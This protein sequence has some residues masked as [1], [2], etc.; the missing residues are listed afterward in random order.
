MEETCQRCERIEAHPRRPWE[1]AMI[2]RS[3]KRD[4]RGAFIAKC[5]CPH[6][7]ALWTRAEDPI[8][9][10]LTWERSD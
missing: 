7:G 1:G 3:V 6:C 10:S 8:K 2:E 5:E 9:G 4:F